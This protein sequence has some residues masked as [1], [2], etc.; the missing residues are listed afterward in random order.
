VSRLL[1]LWACST[2]LMGCILRDFDYEPPPNV[3]PSVQGSQ[4][5]PFD[6]VYVVDIEALP[7]GDGGGAPELEFSADIVDANID[8]EL[9]GLV[10][11]DRD[12][13]RPR[14]Y[15]AHRI[16]PETGDNTPYVR[17]ETFRILRSDIVRPGCHS[18]ELH[19]SRD[20]GEDVVGNPQ[21]DP[22]DLGVGVWWIAAVNSGTTMVDMGSCPS[23]SL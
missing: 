4:E 10:F 6:R 18:V 9:L 17:R 22:S 23:L 3:P 7:G 16:D 5:T 20:F 19:V 8:D 21:A 12:A 1:C 15:S 11:L 14:P 2:C 13:L